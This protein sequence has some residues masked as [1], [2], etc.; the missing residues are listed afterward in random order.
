MTL[1]AGDPAVLWL[2]VSALAVT[3][4]FLS[5][6]M[7]TQIILLL[8]PLIAGGF[9]LAGVPGYGVMVPAV[10]VGFVGALLLTLGGYWRVITD[11]L[12]RV[13]VHMKVGQQQ[14]FRREFFARSALSLFRSCYRAGEYAD[15]VRVWRLALQSSP[16]LAL[17]PKILIKVMVA[18]WLALTARRRSVG[19]A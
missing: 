10:V 16:Q 17:Q 4:A 2:C 18:Q 11:H 14:R 15:A 12:R 5:Q 7:V 9:W 1:Y 3:L 19:S 13:I 6:R 8:V